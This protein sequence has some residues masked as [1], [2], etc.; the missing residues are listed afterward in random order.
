MRENY[1]MKDEKEDNDEAKAEMKKKNRKSP[2]EWIFMIR[3]HQIYILCKSLHKKKRRE[4]KNRSR[5]ETFHRLTNAI[6]K[7]HK[8]VAAGG[9]HFHL[10]FDLVSHCIYEIFKR[11][12]F[13]STSG[14]NYSGQINLWNG[15][16]RSHS[17]SKTRQSNRKYNTLTELK[18]SWC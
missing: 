8:F 1:Q 5:S 7:L 10:A 9:V 18:L 3:S 15:H 16:T 6:H 2:S 17:N 12:A 4:E 11:L 13:G 14:E